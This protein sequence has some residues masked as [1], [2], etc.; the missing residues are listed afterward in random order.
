MQLPSRLST[1]TLGDLLGALHRERTTGLLD[2]C[3]LWTP[4]GTTV[5]GRQHRIQLHGGLV[6][7]VETPIPSLRLGELLERRGVLLSSGVAR[8][9]AATAAR[10]GRL[11]GE[12][13]LASGL[14]TEDDLERT[15]RAQLRARLEALF[16]I[17]EA[18]ICFHTARPLAESLRRVGPLEPTDFLHGRA[19]ARDR[20]RPGPTWSVRPS[21]ASAP[22]PNPSST[23]T[24]SRGP[25]AQSPSSPGF[26]SQNASSRGPSSPGFSSHGPSSRG[27]SSQ[28][29]HGARASSSSG[30]SAPPRGG[31]TSP[32]SLTSLADD[33]KRHALHLLGLPEGASETDVRRAFRRMAARLHPDRAT[34]P[35]TTAR[36][37]ELSAAYHLLVA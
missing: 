29:P 26:A 25:S 10:V 16:A 20:R 24:S 22:P 37:A 2:L 23:G 12:Q 8:L 27:P 15:L 21:G 11:T 9:A 36:F 30:S 35:D 31:R 33:R 34:A 6:T 14:I 19:R 1:S 18:S 4:A 32:S 17:D 3:E 13:L 28:A 7:A 5:P